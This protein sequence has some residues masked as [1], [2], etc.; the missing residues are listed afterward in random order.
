MDLMQA[1]TS[2]LATQSSSTRGEFRVPLVL[3]SPN[4]T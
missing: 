3:W 2:C 4:C 1:T